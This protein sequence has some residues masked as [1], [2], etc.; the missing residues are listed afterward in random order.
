MQQ[1]FSRKTT[2]DKLLEDFEM[3]FAFRATC[4]Q[5]P[6]FPCVEHVELKVL[7]K[8]MAILDLPTVDQWKKIENYGKYMLR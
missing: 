2:I 4:A 3:L 7:E 6:Y 5:L 1:Y 8:E